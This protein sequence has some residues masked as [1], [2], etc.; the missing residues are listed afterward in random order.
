MTPL[1]RLS[2]ILLYLSTSFADLDRHHMVSVDSRHP[3]SVT[4]DGR[5][6]RTQHSPAGVGLLARRS[7]P[8]ASL[9]LRLPGVLPELA[10]DHGLAASVTR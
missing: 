9:A 8:T 4:A 10:H 5:A 1:P 3:V 6:V 2:W 7:A